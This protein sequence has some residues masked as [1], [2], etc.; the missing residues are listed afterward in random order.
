MSD[1]I[2][3]RRHPLHRLCAG[4]RGQRLCRSGVLATQRKTAFFPAQP[5]G[6][7]VAAGIREQPGKKPES[8]SLMAQ[9]LT[10]YRAGR[11]RPNHL[12]CQ[13]PRAL[14]TDE[15]IRCHYESQNANQ[16]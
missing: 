2:V 1:I 8:P 11:L 3:P 7:R 5:R 15:E 16:G 4:I 14:E 9:N 10:R 12:L 6:D 13:D